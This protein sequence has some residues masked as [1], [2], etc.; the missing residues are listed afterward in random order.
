VAWGA[1]RKP[2][3][4]AQAAVVLALLLLIPL[5]IEYVRQ[6]GVKRQW[7]QADTEVASQLGTAQAANATLEARKVYVQTDAYVE[8]AAREQLRMARPGD[9][10]IVMAATPHLPT[11]TPTAAPLPTPTPSSWLDSIFGP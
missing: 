11:A 8:Q 3:K 9:V 7:L 1:P 6:A 10:V 2:S 4:M 5:A